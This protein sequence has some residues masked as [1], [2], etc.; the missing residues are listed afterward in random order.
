M[1]KI[2]WRRKWQPTP[3]FLSRKSHGQ[4]SLAGY[5]T[6]G[7][8][9]RHDL[10][11]G[12]Q[13]QQP[14]SSS[15]GLARTPGWHLGVRLWRGKG[16][17]IRQAKPIL[18]KVQVESLGLYFFLELFT[19]L[20]PKANST[21]KIIA[22]LEFTTLIDVASLVLLPWLFFVSDHHL[23]LYRRASFQVGGLYV[24]VPC[25]SEVLMWPTKLE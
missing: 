14:L 9:V 3:V 4:R 15:S 12:W 10:A 19:I 13:Q 6:W 17:R 20:K 16:W 24:T 8:R 18:V 5:S 11:M 23:C 21:N 1:E 22:F 2:P 7:H 25:D